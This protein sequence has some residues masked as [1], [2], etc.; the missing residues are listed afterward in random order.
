MAEIWI[1]KR[2]GEIGLEDYQD[3]LGLFPQYA[4]RAIASAIRSEGFRLQRII[5]TA[6][7]TGGP[8]GAK[9]PKLSPHTLMIK[10]FVRLYRGRK[11]R[12]A[13]GKKVKGWRDRERH[14]EIQANKHPLQKLAGATRYVYNAPEKMVTVGFLDSRMR[15]L[16]K[17]HAQGFD[18][19][20]S[21]E[22]SRRFHF[23]TRMPLSRGTT[24]LRVPPRPVVSVI[25]EREGRQI[26]QN[27]YSKVFANVARYLTEKAVK[28]GEVKVV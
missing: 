18:I 10:R 11:A 27:V 6:I 13:R 12:M 20:V 22:R 3:L 2:H 7:Q 9:W 15:G 24:R 5:K 8:E 17:M 21:S 19:D 1:G 26:R 14:M 28:A 25:F 16:G 4:D 23:A